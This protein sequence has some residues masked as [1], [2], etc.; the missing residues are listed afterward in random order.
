MAILSAIKS[1]ILRVSGTSVDE[2]FAST[3][4]ICM[5]MADL[6]NE[7]GEEIAKSNDWQALV[8]RHTIV[9][10][11]V[12]AEYPMPSDYDRWVTASRLHDDQSWFW[13]YWHVPTMDQWIDLSNGALVWPTPGAWIM[14]GNVMRFH[15]VPGAGRTATFPYISKNFARD[16]D[17]SVKAAFTADTDEFILPER[18]LRLGLIWKWRQQ[19]RLE[20]A[21]DLATY[22]LALAQEQSRDK[23]A[24]TI[25]E[26][27]QVRRVLG[28]TAA[29]PWPLGN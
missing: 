25:L 16:A 1:A 21:E 9:A 19:K 22:E 26:T 18:L 2:V 3:D 12:T 17:G 23:G 7:L 27:R 5:E 14:F 28:A 24:R 8:S 6:A 29:Y 13:F 15:P 4:Q 10:D 20:Y 11:G